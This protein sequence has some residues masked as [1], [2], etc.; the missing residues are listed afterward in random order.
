VP[1]HSSLSKRERQVMEIIYRDSS[2]SVAEIRAAMPEAVSYSAVRVIVNVLERKGHLKH[3]KKGNRYIYSPT[4][5]RAKA[6]K[7]ALKHLLSTYFGDSLYEAVAAMVQLHARDL[8]GED[9]RQLVATIEKS[10]KENSS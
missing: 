7:G 6:I 9:V 1:S 8:S 3:E 2:A 10:R 5:S 4:V